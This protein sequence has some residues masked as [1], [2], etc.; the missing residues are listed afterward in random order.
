[1][2]AEQ[3]NIQPG[4]CFIQNDH[5]QQWSLCSL[6]R[7][8]GV[9]SSLPFLLLFENTLCC[10]A[11]ATPHGPHNYWCCAFAQP[12]TWKTAGEILLNSSK[13][14]S[15]DVLCFGILT[16]LDADFG[17]GCLSSVVK[18]GC[19]RWASRYRRWTC[20]RLG[21]HSLTLVRVS[22]PPWKQFTFLVCGFV[23]G[24]VKGQLFG[25]CLLAPSNTG[26]WKQPPTPP[27]PRRAFL[28][29]TCCDTEHSAPLPPVFC[30]PSSK[31]ICPLSLS[32]VFRL[33]NVGEA[34]GLNPSATCVCLP[35]PFLISCL[36][37][38]YPFITL[39]HLIKQGDGGLMTESGLGIYST[40]VEKKVSPFAAISCISSSSRSCG[41][42][43]WSNSTGHWL[44]PRYTQQVIFWKNSHWEPR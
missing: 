7:A 6:G 26:G 38:S 37:L 42:W 28:P 41:S 13:S 1:M 29:S 18:T 24:L 23:S 32:L 12:P 19:F 31:P 11:T 4:S 27:Q 43:N 39:T 44:G 10:V 40:V 3:T 25:R 16:A 5:S 21:R 8:G 17:L 33:K 9:S 14:R 30:L 22:S 20:D 34:K 36:P 35:A 15:V 2:K